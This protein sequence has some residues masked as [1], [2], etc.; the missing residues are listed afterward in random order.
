[1]LDGEEVKGYGGF[2]FRREDEALRQA[3]DEQ[4]ASFLGS[5]EHRALVEP[6]GFTPEM[7][8]PDMTVQILCAG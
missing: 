3:F 2:A 8:A 7:I 1:M 4:L 6:F 5:D